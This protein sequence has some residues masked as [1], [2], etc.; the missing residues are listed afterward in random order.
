MFLEYAEESLRILDAGIKKTRAMT[1][2]TGGRIDLGYIYTQG[3]EFVPELVKN[4]HFLILEWS[5]K[6]CRSDIRKL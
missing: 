5:A 1:C 3:I 2:A 4:F 6:N